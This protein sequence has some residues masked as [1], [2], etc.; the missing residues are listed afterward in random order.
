MARTFIPDTDISVASTRGY[1][2]LLKLL[3]NWTPYVTYA[4]L[5]SQ[6][7]VRNLYNNVN[8]NTVPEF[9]PGAA[10]INASQRSG[11][12][13]IRLRPEFLGHW[14]L[15]RVFGDQ[16]AQGRIHA[17]AFGQMSSLV[18]APPGGNVRNQNINVFSVSYNFVF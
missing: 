5:R 17:H 9:I 16:Q 10:L 2:S 4:F 13:H 6:P 1:V 8:Y 18:D 14:H 12:D 3:D 7:H 15:V 11:A